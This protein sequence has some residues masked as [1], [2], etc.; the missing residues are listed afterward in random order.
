MIRKIIVLVVA[1]A[2]CIGLG[3]Y[4]RSYNSNNSFNA[5]QRFNTIMQAADEQA[6]DILKET[7]EKKK[8]NAQLFIERK[9]NLLRHQQK[10]LFN[11]Q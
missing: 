6:Q 9:D 8:K 10:E 2:A 4:I 5:Q 1:I 3:V 7:D 11:Q